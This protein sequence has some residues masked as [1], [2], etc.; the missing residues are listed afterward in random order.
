MGPS[1]ND[2]F[3]FMR[4]E[5]MLQSSVFV[6]RCNNFSN[7]ELVVNFRLKHVSFVLTA[8]KNIVYCT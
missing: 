5:H 8:V 6:S 1:I 2:N 7:N 4:R 3:I